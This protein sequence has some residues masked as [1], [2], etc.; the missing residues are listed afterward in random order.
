MSDTHTPPFPPDSALADLRAAVEH[1]ARIQ[2]VGPLANWC[3]AVDN[4]VLWRAMSP[5]ARAGVFVHVT[6]AE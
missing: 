3:N 5:E 6:P 2:H 1:A 4:G